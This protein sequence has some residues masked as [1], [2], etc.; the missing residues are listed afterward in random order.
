MIVML[1]KPS[2]LETELCT[3]TSVR[4]R[5]VMKRI[6][7]F[8][9]QAHTRLTLYE[10]CWRVDIC[11]DRKTNETVRPRMKETRVSADSGGRTTAPERPRLV[12]KLNLRFIRTR[13]S[14][15]HD[16][17]CDSDTVGPGYRIGGS[18]FA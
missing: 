12:T 8:N 2:E 10:Y 4:D 18:S 6:G 7:T 1:A 17:S 9:E 16:R 3:Y 15:Q 11:N 13:S 5:F 14:A